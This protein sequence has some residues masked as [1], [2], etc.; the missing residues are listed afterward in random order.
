MSDYSTFLE[1]AVQESGRLGVPDIARAR[2]HAEKASLPLDEAIVDL[3]LLSSRD[4][5]LIR[6]DIAETC[7]VDLG[8][9]EPNLSN[10][11]LI[12]QRLAEERVLF[13]LFHTGDVL[14]VAMHD[15][16]DLDALARVR[17]AVRDQVDVVLCE[18]TPLRA[19]IAR[20]Y[21]LAM[22]AEAEALVDL[23]Q[24]PEEDLQ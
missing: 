11:M 8:V 14:T 22:P 19:L 7:F 18:R 16:L 17:E 23:R 13:P 6:A 24:L 1:R 4:V 15:T 21:A 12:P 20:A 3:G 10:A 2:A 9:Y 5:A